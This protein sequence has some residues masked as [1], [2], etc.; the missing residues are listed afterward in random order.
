[1]RLDGAGRRL[2][3][4][5]RRAEQRG[6]CEHCTMARRPWHR[7]PGSAQARTGNKCGGSVMAPAL[8]AQ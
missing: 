4:G 7:S 5:R 1:M 2:S 8:R 6:G 3:G